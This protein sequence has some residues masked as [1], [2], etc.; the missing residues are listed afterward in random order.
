[1]A[2]SMGLLGASLEIATPAFDLLETQDLG[3]AV[4]SVSFSNLQNYAADYKHLQLRL[5]TRDTGPYN[6]ATWSYLRF[7]NDTGS[8]Y[9]WRFFRGNTS[10]ATSFNNY[11]TNNIYCYVSLYNSTTA[12]SFGAAVI[13]ILDFSSTQKRK[14]IGSFAGANAATG[15]EDQVFMAAG[16]WN[17]TSPI[18]TITLQTGNANM[19]AGS[20][21][22]LYGVRG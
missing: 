18:T 4:S 19:Q 7:N 22:S 13:D 21:L 8:N 2:W 1:M 14:T 10:G 9:A 15:G 5:L 16:T 11:P 17:S 3:V 20:R 6:G 12:F